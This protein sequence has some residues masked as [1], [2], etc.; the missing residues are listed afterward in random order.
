MVVARKIFLFCLINPI[1]ALCFTG[2]TAFILIRLTDLSCL[3]C[4]YSVAATIYG[5]SRLSGWEDSWTA[6]AADASSTDLY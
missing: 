6:P 2:E 5:F 3:V 4:V 1:K